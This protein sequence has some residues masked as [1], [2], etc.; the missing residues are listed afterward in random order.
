MGT[1]LD[2]AQAQMRDRDELSKVRAELVIERRA[3]AN[4]QEREAAILARM[5]DRQDAIAALLASDRDVGVSPTPVPV[6]DAVRASEAQ[7][8]AST[9]S[10]VETV[11]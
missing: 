10:V 4:L 9:D 2:L 6:D 5:T 7:E 11:W 3:M 8:E 1:H